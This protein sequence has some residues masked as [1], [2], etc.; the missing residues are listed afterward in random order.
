MCEQKKGSSLEKK[1]KTVNIPPTI[2]KTEKETGKEN[3]LKVA[4]LYAS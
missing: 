2:T 1:K 3:N 4:E